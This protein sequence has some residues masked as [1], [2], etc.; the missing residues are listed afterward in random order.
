M[1]AVTIIGA[2]SKT[3]LD[4]VN[5]VSCNTPSKASIESL[6]CVHII[7]DGAHVNIAYG[8]TDGILAVRPL[9][10]ALIGDYQDAERDRIVC[11]VNATAFKSLLSSLDADEEPKIA[12][13]NDEPSAP[14][15][16]VFG[17]MACAA[18]SLLCTHT[19]GKIS[20]KCCTPFC[21]KPYAVDES[22]AKW[23]FTMHAKDL[24]DAFKKTK[25]AMACDEVRR[26]MNGVCI[27]ENNGKFDFCATDGRKLTVL[28][29][30]IACPN[31]NACIIVPTAMIN[32]VLQIATNCEVTLYSAVDENDTQYVLCVSS[33][34]RCYCRA[35]EGNYPN[36]YVVIP[37]EPVTTLHIKRDSL[38]SAIKRMK[39]AEDGSDIVTFLEDAEQEMLMSRRV[40]MWTRAEERVYTVI[41]GDKRNCLPFALSLSILRDA[42]NANTSDTIA[43]NLVSW[44][45]PIW[46]CADNLTILMMPCRVPEEYKQEDDDILA[47]GKPQE[48]AEPIEE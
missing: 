33:A 13:I 27:R 37:K 30:N 20:L 8:G 17:Q 32:F 16:E 28:N 29:T 43:L 48:A 23:S 5:F 38:L 12:L 35:I 21:F 2:T 24:K 14:L 6:S 15:S 36:V 40:D 44:E 46:S 47:A 42:L 11:A 34:G 4:A 45:R 25:W 19:M 26:V 31:T 41:E 9:A 3:W 39:V 22:K 18:Q 1:K 10:G 7:A